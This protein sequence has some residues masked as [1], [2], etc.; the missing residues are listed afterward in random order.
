MSTKSHFDKELKILK[1]N[2][3]GKLIIEDFLPEFE[4][5]IK[6]FSK[7]GHSGGS[8]AL[9]A[10]SLSGQFQKIYY[11]EEKKRIKKRN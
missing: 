3:D 4:N 8:G 7:Q 1:N 5:I 10:Q 6:K 11:Y 9:Y 2:C